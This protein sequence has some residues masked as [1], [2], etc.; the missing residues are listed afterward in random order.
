MSVFRLRYIPI[1]LINLKKPK[2]GS[3]VIKRMVCAYVLRF[4]GLCIPNFNF[5]AHSKRRRTSTPNEPQHAE[6]IFTLAASSSSN[7][8]HRRRDSLYTISGNPQ[9]D[10]FYRLRRDNR[11]EEGKTAWNVKKRREKKIKYCWTKFGDILNSPL[12]IVADFRS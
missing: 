11:H 12:I 8:I 2:C 6:Q 4:W 10:S 3:S 9:Q 5:T 1:L 7:M